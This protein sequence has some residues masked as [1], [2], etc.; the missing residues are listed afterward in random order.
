MQPPVSP[1]DPFGP[2]QP[3]AASSAGPFSPQR[4]REVAIPKTLGILNLIFGVIFMLAGAGTAIQY[5][6]MPMFGEV[7]EAQQQQMTKAIELQQDSAVQKLLEEQKAAASEDEKA[8]IQTQIDQVQ[9]QPTFT[10]PNMA[11]MMG[12][13]DRRVI[14]WG[15]VNSLTG[16]LL[17][18]L[19]IISGVGLLLLRGWGRSLALWAAGLKIVRL[20]AG[21]S[22]YCFVCV[23]VRAESMMGFMDQVGAQAGPSQAQPPVE[24][25]MMFA[26]RYWAQAVGFALFASI[27]PIV[28]LVLLTRSRVKAAFNNAPVTTSQ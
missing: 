15:V 4:P 23:P 10:T 14:I 18:L 27:Y 21:Q 12:M 22:Y 13:N 17:N 2:H 7:M 9:N 6:V 20:I 16:A 8:V 25:G 1:N 5:L 24:M 11:G 19:M 28:C 26:G 3:S